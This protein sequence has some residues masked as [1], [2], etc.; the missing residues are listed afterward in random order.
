MG[1]LVLAIPEL[2]KWVEVLKVKKFKVILRYL[3]I[4]G[5]TGIP[6][7]SGISKIFCVGEGCLC[8]HQAWES[9]D[10]N[11]AK[12]KSGLWWCTL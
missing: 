12:R 2:R 8:D 11:E 3:L 6:Q 4:S 7:Y 10:S 1:G 5:T 9:K